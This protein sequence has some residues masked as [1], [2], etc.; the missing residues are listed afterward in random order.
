MDFSNREVKRAQ[1]NLI[2][3]KLKN[4]GVNGEQF[5][6]ECQKKLISELQIEDGGKKFSFEKI[7]EKNLEKNKLLAMYLCLRF[8]LSGFEVEYKETKTEYISIVKW[9]EWQ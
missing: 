5:Y 8:K 2:D 9:F 7:D 4:Y 1:V 6:I 3:S